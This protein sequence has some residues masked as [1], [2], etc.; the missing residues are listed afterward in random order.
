MSVWI[1]TP[2]QRAP[3]PGRM[4]HAPLP[5]AG[6]AAAP[7]RRGRIPPAWLLCQE[8]VREQAAK[9]GRGGHGGVGDMQGAR[10]SPATPC[11]HSGSLG[12]MSVRPQ[13]EG[14]HPLAPLH[15]Q[16]TS[17][18]SQQQSKTNKQQLQILGFLILTHYGLILETWLSVAMRLL[19]GENT[20][21]AQPD[22]QPPALRAEVLFPF[23]KNLGTTVLLKT[24]K[25]AAKVTAKQSSLQRALGARGTSG[26][27]G[28]WV[29]GDPYLEPRGCALGMACRGSPGSTPPLP[30]PPSSGRS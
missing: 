7:S 21:L 17:Q 25:L 5:P 13:P 29:L 16:L 18:M 22:R 24:I 2:P 8:G 30:V 27:W 12:R 4:L 14:H 1:L 20:L 19:L 26:R 10:L 15:N 6:E 23:L 9:L 28:T 11:Q 3:A